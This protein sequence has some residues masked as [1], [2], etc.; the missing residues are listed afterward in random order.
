LYSGEQF[1]SKIGQQYLRARYYDP[2]TGRFNRL[3]PFFG[4]LNDPQSLHKYLYTH[5]DPVNGIDPTGKSWGTVAIAV[6]VAIGAGIGAWYGGAN[7]G[8]KGAITG[9]VI[10]G[11]I[12]GDLATGIVSLIGVAPIATQWIGS[13]VIVGIT[14]FEIGH[15]IT[16]LRSTPT[17][18]SAID[19]FFTRHARLHRWGTA[20]Q[21]IKRN[22]INIKKYAKENNLPA[23]IVASVLLAEQYH[24]NLLDVFGDGVPSDWKIHSVGIAQLRVDTI[25]SH[26]NGVP[27]IFIDYA[28][29]SD[30][31]IYQAL[32]KDETAIQLLS[33]ELRYR[34]NQLKIIDPQYNIDNWSNMSETEKCRLIW[35]LTN[36]K[37]A[38]DTKDAID[39]T[40]FGSLGVA[41]YDYL[42]EHSMV[43][44]KGSWDTFSGEFVGQWLTC[45]NE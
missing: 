2:V 25:T 1:D 7:Y 23:I 9:A 16:V 34:V 21:V 44:C 37:D 14:T 35:I 12:M 8:W 17:W 18:K 29:M 33:M 31:D 27:Q 5:D 38:I 10:G 30:E 11:S 32:W 43:K 4:N 36:C 42:K 24:Y 19:E 20:E 28:F 39:G 6:S 40:M 45:Y 13:S 15:F 22:V 26:R 3:D 41:G